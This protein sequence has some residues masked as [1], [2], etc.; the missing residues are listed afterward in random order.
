MRKRGNSWKRRRR[1]RELGDSGQPGD[2]TI[3]TAEGSKFRGNLEK[4]SVGGPE[5]RGFGA[6]RRF[7]DGATGRCE[8]QGNLENHQPGPEDENS[9]QPGAS[10]EAISEERGTGATRN[11]ITDTAEGCENRG[12]SEL[13]RRQ[14]RKMQNSGQPEDSS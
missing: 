11:F 12:N 9:G 1:S 10:S 5:E 13:H 2:S 6:T 3:G 7:T 8:I 14:S 4:R